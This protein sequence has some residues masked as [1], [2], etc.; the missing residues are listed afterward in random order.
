MRR[1]IEFP[2]GGSLCRGWLYSPDAPA[3]MQPAPAIVM[4]H[5]FSA[6][7]EMFRLS[8]YAERIEAAGF[9]VLVFDF[10]FLGAS[11]GNPRGQIIFHDQQE[12][13]RNAITW[14]SLQP[15]VD[16]DRIG[17]W[18]TS[19]SGGHVLHLAAFDRRIK[20]VVAQVPTIDPVKQIVHRIGKDGLE[21]FMGMLATDR[22]QRFN[23]GAVNYVQIVGLPGELSVL[24]V[25]D[26]YGAMMKYASGAPTWNNQITLESLEKYIE[27][28]P[29]ASIELISPTPLLMVL[30]EQDSV[31]PVEL[32]RAAFD[33][34]GEPKD[35]Q[36][37]PCG[38]FEV[39]DT[40]PWF[41]KA[42]GSMV[43]WYIK[44]L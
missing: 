28:V 4:A 24:S 15:E 22:A 30:A 13:Y 19:L 2:S 8:S 37:V 32:A 7:K 12:D 17:V 41:S 5:G 42:V 1:D 14:L 18:G 44:Y 31:I 35:L 34:A 10:R 20:A 3:G 33:R 16:E 23:D 9:M 40:E 38:H 26:A 11:D 36:V 43:E 39:Y 27:Y 29:T 25:P 21:Q 6:V